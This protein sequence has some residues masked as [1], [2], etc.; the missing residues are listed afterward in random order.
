LRECVRE[1]EYF[2]SFFSCFLSFSAR[3]SFFL[4]GKRDVL[5]FFSSVF[6]RPFHAGSVFLC[7]AEKMLFFKVFFNKRV[8]TVF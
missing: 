5:V 3:S 6:A 2:L 8:I 1:M 4:Y 7:R